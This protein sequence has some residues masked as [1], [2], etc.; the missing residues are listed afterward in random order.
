[1]LGAAIWG[2]GWVAGEHL[3]AYLA[4]PNTHVV[5]I[6]SRT[7]EGARARATES[8]VECDVYDDLDEMLK[9]DDLDV[10]S[11]CTPHHLHVSDLEKIA[12]AGKHALL[13]KPM[14]L[15]LDDLKRERDIVR[16]TGI[17]TLVGFE[18]HWNPYVV[19]LRNLIDDGTLGDIVFM[20]SGYFSEVGP[21]WPGFEWGKTKE[22][23]GSVISV[24]SCHAVDL[25]CSFG[26]EVAEVF[27]YQTRR[28]RQDL[29][30]DPTITG[31][32]K[33]KNGIV[34]S[35]SSSFEIHAPYVLPIVIGGSKGAVR[36]GRLHA[37]RFQGQTD[38]IELPTIMP[39]TPD[40]THH[41]FSEEID[42]FVDCI[43]N[44]EEPFLCVEKASRVAE[45]GF[46]L[47][48]SAETNRPVTLPLSV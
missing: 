18:L 17:K 43:L 4:N 19:M 23:G 14:A 22:K 36:N 34:A 39:D 40:V 6:G 3:K 25:L 12:T 8:G 16:K 27:A 44:D 45:V 41:P 31:V 38:W 42:Y 26:G 20:E 35:L 30:Y 11:I 24:A 1:M 10:V 46:A 32:L 2:G 48:R 9:R 7:K 29:E 13:E 33:F 21:W 5:A 15:G 47:E 37:E 28:T